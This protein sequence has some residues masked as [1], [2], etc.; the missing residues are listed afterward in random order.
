MRF[1]IAMMRAVRTGYFPDRMSGAVSP[2]KDARRSRAAILAAARELFSDGRDVPMYEIGRRA[3]VGHATLYRHFPDRAAIAEAVV[4]EQI[5][6]LEEIV[7]ARA[8]DRRA[9]I[10]AL[11]AS[12]DALVEIHDLVGILRDDPAL[13]PVLA[14]LR[15]RVK[16]ALHAAF[17]SSRREGL[18]R[19][20]VDIDDLMLV[21]SMVNGALHGIATIRQ[22]RSVADRALDIALRGLLSGGAPALQTGEAAQ[23]R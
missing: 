18:L 22:R 20:D 14:R 5:E 3:G 19:D 23:R 11:E 17:E 12:V 16:A 15:A 6:R 21:L 10:M 4:S 9:I 8:G 7:G 13:A 2:R 1:A